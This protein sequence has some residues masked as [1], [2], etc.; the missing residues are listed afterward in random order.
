MG[1][2][3]KLK[4]IVQT[5]IN[6]WNGYDEA[7]DVSAEIIKDE[8]QQENLLNKQK[9]EMIT[10]QVMMEDVE[11]ALKFQEEIEMQHQQTMKNIRVE[12]KQIRTQQLGQ[13]IELDIQE[14]QEKLKEAIQLR[15]LQ[16]EEELNKIRVSETFNFYKVKDNLAKGMNLQSAL[17]AAGCFENCQY[18]LNY[19]GMGFMRLPNKEVDNVCLN[20]RQNMFLNRYLDSKNGTVVLVGMPNVYIY[21]IGALLYDRDIGFILLKNDRIYDEYVTDIVYKMECHGM[22]NGERYEYFP[23]SKTYVKIAGAGAFCYN[24]QNQCLENDED[25]NLFIEM[26]QMNPYALNKL[27]SL[28]DTLG[29]RRIN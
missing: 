4:S 22:F 14:Q 8:I 21:S 5:S 23:L 12:S 20:V 28:L 10:Q 6:A 7:V 17:D 13:N 3:D 19:G 18:K 2:T 16:R 25:Y 1:L 24:M 9:A 11:S 29:L 26:S 27:N 15:Q